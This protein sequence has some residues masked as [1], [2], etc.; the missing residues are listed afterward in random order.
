MA[1][2]NA[3]AAKLVKRTIRKPKLGADKKPELDKSNNVI[4]VESEVDVKTD[5][6]LAVV[7]HEDNTVTVITN[8]GLKLRAAIPAAK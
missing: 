7:E 1:L 6:V 5:E 2:T 8:D 3:Q 4:L